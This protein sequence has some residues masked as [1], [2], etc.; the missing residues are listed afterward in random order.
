MRLDLVTVGRKCATSP[1]MKE[2]VSR[3]RVATWLFSST[4]D[5]MSLTASPDK[6]VKRE[7]EEEEKAIL[8]SARRGH[9]AAPGL[10]IYI[11][12]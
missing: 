6:Q 9:W 12:V 8:D 1:T 2:R 10:G 3:V 4:E 11:K 5:S 7:F